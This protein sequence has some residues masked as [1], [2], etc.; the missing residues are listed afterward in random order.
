MQI[1]RSD[2]FGKSAQ[3]EN[4]CLN[5]ARQLLEQRA[6]TCFCLFYIDLGKDFVPIEHCNLLRFQFLVFHLCCMSLFFLISHFTAPL[7][8]LR[9]CQGDSFITRR[10]AFLTIRVRP[11]GHWEPRNKIGCQCLAELTFWFS[12]LFQCFALF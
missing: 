5:S 11:E 4:I 2:Q 6:R 12:P 7:P 9:H 1:L 10:S 3:L 8:S